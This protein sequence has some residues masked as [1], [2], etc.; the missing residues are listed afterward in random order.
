MAITVITPTQLTAGTEFVVTAG[1]GT[2]INTENTMSIAYPKQGKLL[3]YIDSNHASTSA[4]F[5]AGD[6]VSKDLGAFAWAVGDTVAEMMVLDSDRLVYSS[7]NLV[8]TWAT[9]SAG[10]LAA[11]YMPA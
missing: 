2:A 8:I 11:W 9:D 3:L 7:G 10:F 6:G 1:V 5:A 4:S